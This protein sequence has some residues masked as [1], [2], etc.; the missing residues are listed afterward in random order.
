MCYIATTAPSFYMHGAV[1]EDHKTVLI[2]FVIT[3]QF[4]RA[5]SYSPQAWQPP[6]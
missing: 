2:G 5:Y 4:A 6:H 1:T 3:V